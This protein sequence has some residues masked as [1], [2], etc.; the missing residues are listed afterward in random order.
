MAGV[1]GARVR[2]EARAARAS[3]SGPRSRPFGRAA[4]RSRSEIHREAQATMARNP[5]R[6]YGPLVELSRL[7][8]ELNR[9]FQS[10]S[11]RTT[12][13][14]AS[15]SWDPTGRAR[16]RPERSGSCSSCPASSPRTSGHDPGPRRHDPRPEEGPHPDPR[17]DPLLLHGAL[18]RQLREV[19]APARARSTP[20]KRRLLR[21]GLLEVILPRVPDQREKE[22]EIAV[23]P[24]ED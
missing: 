16:R 6:L 7:Q 2:A 13:R 10:S 11:R 22:H 8:G 5:V 14:R 24:E 3:G 9:L 21:N 15:T 18:L 19:R 20:A 17:G 1:R 23:R 12:R 4:G